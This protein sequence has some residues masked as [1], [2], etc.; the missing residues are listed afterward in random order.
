[1]TSNSTATII[2]N[3]LGGRKFIIMTG[4][5]KLMGETNGLSFKLPRAFAKNNVNHVS[6]KLNQIDLY[7]ITY[8]RI[9]GGKYKVIAKSENIYNDMLQ[10]DFTDNTGLDCTFGEIYHASI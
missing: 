8:S 9:W 2:L 1:M 5:S 7:D 10:V 4:A 3:Q 6:I